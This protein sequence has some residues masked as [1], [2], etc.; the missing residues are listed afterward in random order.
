MVAAQVID[1]DGQEATTLKYFYRENG[2]VRLQPAHPE[3]PPFIYPPER[4]TVQGKV[5]L[6][7]RQ[8]G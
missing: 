3:M 6:V 1:D 4:V 5:V 7:I 2:H 8:V